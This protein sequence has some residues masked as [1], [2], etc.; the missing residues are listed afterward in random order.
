M[1]A[2]EYV[3]GQIIRGSMRRS[4]RDSICQVRDAEAATI[5]DIAMGEWHGTPLVV[6]V[7]FEVYRSTKPIWI[8]NA[9]S[10]F[11]TID[12]D[13]GKIM[14]PDIEARDNCRHRTIMKI[15]YSGDMCRY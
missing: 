12:L 5:L 10:S 15:H 14:P 8:G 9:Q 7:S 6:I 11:G 13:P 4:I 3:V 2:L 1:H